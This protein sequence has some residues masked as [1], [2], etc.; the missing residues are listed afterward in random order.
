MA[1]K[2][3]CSKRQGIE[4]ER[5]LGPM[6][7]NWQSVTSAIILLLKAVTEP[8][9]TRGEGNKLLLSMRRVAHNMWP[10]LIYHSYRTLC[11]PNGHRVSDFTASASLSD[12]SFLPGLVPYTGQDNQVAELT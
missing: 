9:D 3:E 2:K 11:V 5:R 8:S 12:R 4:T 7:R 1:S 10:S 6:L